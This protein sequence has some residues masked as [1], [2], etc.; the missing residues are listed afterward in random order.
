MSEGGRGSTRTAGYFSPTLL[1]V[2]HRNTGH[3]NRI[4]RGQTHLGDNGVYSIPE[5]LPNLDIP[6]S[7]RKLAS[8]LLAFDPLFLQDDRMTAEYS[9]LRKLQGVFLRPRK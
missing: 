1:V 7:A 2:K 6:L 3:P 9:D 8:T 5:E 4:K